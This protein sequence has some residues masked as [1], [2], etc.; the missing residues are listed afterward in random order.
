MSIYVKLYQ[1]DI[2]VK[3][4]ILSRNNLP[5][6]TL[7]KSH[8]WKN[9]SSVMKKIFRKFVVV[10]SYPVTKIGVKFRKFVSFSSLIQSLKSF[11]G[12]CICVCFSKSFLFFVYDLTICIDVIYHLS[13]PSVH[14]F[15]A[16]NHYSREAYLPISIRYQT[17][18]SSLNNIR[19]HKAKR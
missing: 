8:R 6:C 18:S 19:T 9:A 3:L 14:Q 17:F 10:I 13:K 1:C 12:V 15:P 2:R 5:E 7:Q 11:T 4:L 16:S